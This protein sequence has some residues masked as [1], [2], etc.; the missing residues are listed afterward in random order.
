MAKNGRGLVLPETVFMQ[1]CQGPGELPQP[2]QTTPWS[3]ILSLHLLQNNNTTTLSTFQL[4]TSATMDVDSYLLQSLGYWYGYYVAEHKDFIL[5]ALHL[6]LSALFPI[7][8]GAHASLAL[9]PSAAK[10][11]HKKRSPGTATSTDDEDDDLLDEPKMDGMRPTDAIWFPV[12][13]GATLTGLYYLIKWLKDPAL[14]NKIMTY[15]FSGIGIFGVGNLAAN[16]L[17]V[18]TSFIFP[19][20]WAGEGRIYAIKPELKTQAY[21]TRSEIAQLEPSEHISHH[22]HFA[23]NKVTPLPGLLS[24]LNFGKRINN[25]LWTL[26]QLLTQRWI[27]RLHIHPLISEKH[28]IRLTDMLG[29]LLGMVAIA[30]YNI[31]DKPW[32]MTNIIGFG[33]CYG[34]LQILS[35]TTFWT[36]TMVLAGLFV[37]DIVMV[38]YTPMMVTVAT[39]L[40]VPI[41]L[42]LPGPRGG[43]LGLGDIVL[44]GIMMAM[45]LRFDLY[46]HFLRASKI[47][48]HK[49][50]GTPRR[51]LAD[52]G[53]PKTSYV[54]ELWWTRSFKAARSKALKNADFKKTY[55]AASI[56]GYI[57]GMTVTM[58]I[59]QVYKHAQPALLYLVPAVLGSLWGTALVRGEIG[60]MWRFT[61]GGDPISDVG[62]HLASISTEDLKAINE[63]QDERKK[64]KK[65]RERK[66]K[67]AREQFAFLISLSTPTKKNVVEAEVVPKHEPGLRATRSP[68]IGLSD[69]ASSRSG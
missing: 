22:V 5:M 6:L 19:S 44:P 45:A 54:G 9:P 17:N 23:E 65:E 55:F 15:Y 32:Y 7:Y 59:L 49:P 25:Q 47:L 26:R 1:G 48:G 37:Y 31:L 60:L 8:T 62:D 40:E 16:T 69:A 38:F 46:L 35:P 10:P 58:T 33:F 24:H 61:E 42:V 36:G 3:F 29:I 43:M 21:N 18:I 2:R 57:A 34:T 56:V 51:Q 27:F 12:M 28:R 39:S 50:D 13:A 68:D 66:D 14:I 52:Y 11:Q 4:S 20:V 30:L 64:E 41:K 67:K 63:F 53:T